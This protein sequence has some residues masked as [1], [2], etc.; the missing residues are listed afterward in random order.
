MMSAVLTFL[1]GKTLGRAILAATVALVL[2]GAWGAWQ[3]HEGYRTGYAEAEQLWQAKYDKLVADIEKT[4][5][6][7][8]AR[9]EAA[10]AV[11]RR[12]ANETISKL[13]YRLAQQDVIMK[14][15]E[16]AADSDPDALREC[17]G[18]DS[19]R[20]LNQNSAGR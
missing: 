17:L 15:L 11:A 6:D 1:L 14:E 4:S 12:D 2:A 20:R 19:V 13:R 3:H 8:S 16:D 18:A 10:N 7:E 9:Q 5:A